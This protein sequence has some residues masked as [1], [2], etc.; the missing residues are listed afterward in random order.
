MK[1]NHYHLLGRKILASM[2]VVPAVPFV[3]LLIIGSYYFITTAQNTTMAKMARIVEDHRQIVDSFLSERESDLQFAA[4]SYDI[5]ELIKPET[6]S[7]VFENL[8][9]KSAAF[10]DFG[11]FNQ[12]GVHVAYH[13]PYALAGKNYA[14][15]PWFRQVLKDGLYISDVFLGYRNIPH[16]I[17]A[18]V[19]KTG[20]RTWILR[21]TIDTSIFKNVVEKIRV[22]KT[23]EAYILNMEGRFQ[24]QRRSGGDLMS[25]DPTLETMPP[26][27]LAVESTVRKDAQGETFL[28]AATW[29]KN[30][31]WLL[32]ARQEKAEAF[33]D[34]NRIAY[35]VILVILVGGLMIVSLALYVSRRLVG[36]MEHIDTEKE[37]L[38]RQLIVAGRLAEIG[39][40]SAGFAHEINN[41]LQIIRSEQT[42][43]ETIL[44]DMKERGDV[45]P[46]EDLAQIHDSLDQIKFQVDRA[47][48][49]TQGILKFARKK[50]S[51]IR[52]IDLKVFVPEI[53]TLV[54]RKANVEGIHV[55]VEIDEGTPLITGDASQLEQVVVNL[56]NNAIYAIVERHGPSGGE[57]VVSAAP[58]TDGEVVLS[59]QDNGGGISPEDMEKIFTPFFTTKPVGKGTGLGL[60]I[61]Y[62]IVGKMG[63]HMEVKSE[64]GRGTTF[65]IRLPKV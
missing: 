10:T 16:F 61:C 32:V 53:I 39:E 62:G 11:V 27:N 42:L 50:E 40:M 34:L 6:M 43:I 60:S 15:A 17:I 56:L 52:E 46:S 63:G 36:E 20:D 65:F 8:Q 30:K 45:P 28:Y 13:G 14:D 37:E 9:K 26:V 51:S 49:I 4:D 35:L 1:D 24:T 19:K 25:K 41:P 12:T 48:G 54:K 44:E 7:Q 18:V 21:A 5:L 2:L 57:L 31:D 58:V 38:G 33:K 59:V 3:L 55:A 22:G 64:T 47:G 29:L 23:G